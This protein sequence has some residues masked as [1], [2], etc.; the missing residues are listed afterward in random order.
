MYKRQKIESIWN[1]DNPNLNRVMTKY[2]E[3]QSLSAKY[4]LKSLGIEM[5]IRD[6]GTGYQSLPGSGLC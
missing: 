5:C 3:G 6:R 1:K 2:E 4:G